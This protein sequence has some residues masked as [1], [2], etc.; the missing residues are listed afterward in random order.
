MLPAELTI[1]EAMHFSAYTRVHLYNLVTAGK[2][3]SKR[4]RMRTGP[5]IILIERSSLEEYMYKQGRPI[6]G[7]AK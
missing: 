5:I 2:L 6:N 4:A 3:K 7:E 1:V